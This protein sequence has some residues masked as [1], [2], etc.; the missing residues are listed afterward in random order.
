MTCSP[1]LAETQLVVSDVLRKRTDVER[2][3]APAAVRSVV[4]DGADIPL[5]DRDD[6]QLWPHVHGTDAMHLTLLRRTA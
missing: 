4:R 6:V 1:H 2:L 3:D 5:A